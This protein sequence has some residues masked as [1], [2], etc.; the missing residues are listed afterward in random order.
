MCGPERCVMTLPRHSTSC[1]RCR[2]QAQ[3][4]PPSPAASDPRLTSLAPSANG[5]PSGRAPRAHSAPPPALLHP[6]P[7]P[8]SSQATSP[9]L[10]AAGQ[11]RA[12][13]SACTLHRGKARG[14]ARSI[15]G[16]HAAAAAGLAAG[17]RAGGN[18]GGGGA[19]HPAT[20]SASAHVHMHASLGS[21]A[22][23]A[24]QS[25]RHP[26]SESDWQRWQMQGPAAADGSV[27]HREAAAA[28]VEG[29]DAF[30]WVAQAGRRD[31][32]RDVGK[33][34][35]E[36]G[37]AVL[38]GGGAVRLSVDSGL[39]RVRRAAAAAA[40]VA[41]PALKR[42]LSSSRVVSGNCLR[43]AACFGFALPPVGGGPI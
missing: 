27:G 11:P 2:V 40:A 22:S 5:T 31:G 24:P 6:P 14:A 39:L 9:A 7:H 25:A 20:P 13:A 35:Q 37:G 36:V 28:A 38:D 8:A 16:Q 19:S 42:A 33:V 41:S 34:Q 43:G 23:S 29:G 18:G 15:L 30:A 26:V 3:A 17:P 12:L 21:G 1:C 4:R 10:S 32:V